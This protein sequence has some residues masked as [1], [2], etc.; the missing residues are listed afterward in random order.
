MINDSFYPND[1]YPDGLT[2]DLI[3]TLIRDV[4]D[5]L[6]DTPCPTRALLDGTAIHQRERRQARRALTAVVRTLPTPPGHYHDDDG[7]SR[8]CS[9]G[10]A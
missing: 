3:D 6:T 4:A 9:V 7:A 8:T 5:T 2:P 10:A 1:F